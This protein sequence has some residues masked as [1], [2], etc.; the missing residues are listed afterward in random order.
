MKIGKA[1]D[2][3]NLCLKNKKIKSFL[4]ESELLI[5]KA[6]NKKR[7]YIILNQ[8]KEINLDEY[9]IFKKMIYER[10]KGK[11]IAYLL[12]KKYFWKN[13]F[14]V[15]ES[16]LIPR[17]DTEVIIEEVLNIYKNKNKINFLDIG[18]GSGTIILSILNEKKQFFGTGIDLSAGCLSVCRKNAHKFKVNDRLKLFK[19]DIDNFS[20]GKYDLIISNPPYINKLDLN[21]LDKDIKYFEP[22]LALDGGLDGLSEIRK[23]INKATELIKKN[24]RLI[25]EIAFNQKNDVK[26]ILMK[27]GFF[28][29]AV[30]QDLAKNDRCIVSRKI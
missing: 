2:E 26:K 23:I 3:G 19:S 21:K 27:K 9:S 16:V 14:E 5:S 4:I 8:D 15:N 20:W 25:L 17:P 6:M 7:E 11:P 18:V 22:F 1:I 24:G 12:G 30:V 28:I 29:E 10:S 13:E